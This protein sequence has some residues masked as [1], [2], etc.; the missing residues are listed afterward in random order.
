MCTESRFPRAS[1]AESPP[2]PCPAAVAVGAFSFARS[3][4]CGGTENA[5]V[6]R[7]ARAMSKGWCLLSRG[8]SA[9]HPAASAEPRRPT[10][11]SQQATLECAANTDSHFRRTHSPW[12][13]L[14]RFVVEREATRG[15]R[16]GGETRGGVGRGGVRTTG[17][18]APMYGGQRWCSA[19]PCWDADPSH[20]RRPCALCGGS[21]AGK[22]II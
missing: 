21:W 3:T 4:L 7:V 18:V 6:L 10:P 8:G 19:S 9:D 22:S 5:W 17:T 15:G 12:G 1:A 11:S 13:A 14:G 16:E 2:P 20:A